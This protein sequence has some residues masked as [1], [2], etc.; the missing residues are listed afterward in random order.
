MTKS[1]FPK[2][3]SEITLRTISLK[4]RSSLQG[5]NNKSQSGINSSVLQVEKLEHT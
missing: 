1:L 3:F 5:F 2:S 4:V